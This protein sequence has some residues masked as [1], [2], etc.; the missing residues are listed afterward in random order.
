[1]ARW[2]KRASPLHARRNKLKPLIRARGQN[3]F[4]CGDF[5]V[6]AEITIEHLT[7]KA[8]GGSNKRENLYLAHKDCNQMAGHMDYLQKMALRREL[9]RKH[10]NK[11][12]GCP[13]SNK[14]RNKQ[15]K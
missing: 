12:G 7:A 5:M 8:N 11:L 2:K 6:L 4:Y 1:M 15:E 13:T 3:C 9:H 10:G 14:L